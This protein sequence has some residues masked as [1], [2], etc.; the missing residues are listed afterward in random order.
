MNVSFVCFDV[1]PVEVDLEQIDVGNKIS[2][3]KTTTFGYV[4]NGL[5]PDVRTL[6]AVHIEGG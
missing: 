1:R 4:R 3:K 6:F 5:G 2:P